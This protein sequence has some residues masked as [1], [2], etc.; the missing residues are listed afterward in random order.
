MA[1]AGSTS[2]L[3]LPLYVV[4]VSDAAGTNTLFAVRNGGSYATQIRI[5]Y[6]RTDQPQVPQRVDQVNLAAK[7]VKTVN[8]RLVEGLE[9]DTSGLARGYVVVE[10]LA[11]SCHRIGIVPGLHIYTFSASL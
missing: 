1:S 4:D 5:S 7:A 8:I 3:L 10:T 11:E 6:F 2:R 9:V